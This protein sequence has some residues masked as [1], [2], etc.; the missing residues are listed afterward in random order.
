MKRAIVVVA[1]LALLGAGAYFV[2]WRPRQESVAAPPPVTAVAQR[3]TLRLTVPSTGR[4][5]SNLDVDIKCKASGAIIELPFDVGDAVKKD[6]LLVKLDPVDEQRVLKQAEVALEASQAKLAV[7][8]QNL[9]VAERTLETD[10]QR[11]EAALR[12]AEAAARDARAKADRVKDL[13]A[14]DLASQEEY[15]TAE[16]LATQGAAELATAKARIAELQTQFLALE[17][18][19]Q[20]VKLAEAQ[21]EGNQVGLSIAQDRLR[22]TKVA[23]PIDSI[24]A[25]RN[26]QI[27]QIISSGI[28]NVGGG[29][30]ILTLSDL[31]RIFVLA[32]VDESD[33]GTVRLGQPVAIT[34]DAFPAK[35]FQGEVVRIATRGV[36][37][38]N[39]VTFE[40]KIEVKGETKALL[41]PE[42]TANVEIVTEVKEGVLLVP[43]EA[44]VRQ[45]GG[46]RVVTVIRDD[47]KTEDVV[48]EPGLSDGRVTE[49]L[50]GLAE[51][52]TV[53]ERPGASESKWR[54]EAK[55]A[56]P[57]PPGPLAPRGGKKGQAP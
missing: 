19:R 54:A 44:I 41:K 46:R 50:S 6:E 26:V 12:S 25:A 45:A 38:S 40:V 20:E 14:A 42:M 33:I 17:L 31:S 4:V 34:A 11:A 52:Q 48:V 36:N 35:A 47:G 21:V 51:G 15:D 1:V 24:V 5:V 53:V 23:A 49:V 56:G 10:R 32:S 29:T 28:S 8:R 3:G 16:T 55:A 9:I 30:T 22:D 57:Q 43:G 18:H 13:L 7:A 27:G 2:W 37:L 39:V